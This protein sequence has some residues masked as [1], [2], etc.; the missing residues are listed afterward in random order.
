MSKRITPDRT[1]DTAIPVTVTNTAGLAAFLAT[2]AAD[3]PAIH[4]VAADLTATQ[5]KSL[6]LAIVTNHADR[7][8]DTAH[9]LTAPT[10]PSPVDLVRDHLANLVEKLAGFV[11]AGQGSDL[12]DSSA[13][14]PAM[15][16]AALTRA[17]PDTAAVE[18]VLTSASN[19]TRRTITRNFSNAA[20]TYSTPGRGSGPGTV[21]V[22]VNKDGVP[23]FHAD[24]QKFNNATAAL[25]CADGW[26]DEKG[27]W[28][29][30]YEVMTDRSGVK[31]GDRAPEA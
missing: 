1:A 22:T 17:T 29:N 14:I 10:G 5:R 7:A 20:G 28:G 27:G 9:I 25:K 26:G 31:L 3:I 12:V 11:L 23:A 16:A 4:A 2:E 18:K 19:R 15:L 24:G 6:V 21:K 8:A 13:D 30:P